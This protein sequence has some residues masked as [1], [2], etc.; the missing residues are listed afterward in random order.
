MIESRR[1]R[2]RRQKRWDIQGTGGKWAVEERDTGDR[3]RAFPS[4]RYPHSATRI[5]E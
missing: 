3:R 1:G 2:G 4:W 5:H